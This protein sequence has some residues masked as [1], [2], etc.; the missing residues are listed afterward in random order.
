EVLDY[1]QKRQQAVELRAQLQELVLRYCG[2]Y[3]SDSGSKVYGLDIERIREVYPKDHEELRIS[4]FEISPELRQR[5]TALSFKRVIPALNKAMAVAE[6][7]ES[8]I[9]DTFGKGFD[10]NDIL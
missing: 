5:L 6:G 3:Q 7:W 10:K 1:R 4:E 9:V 2:C 8:T